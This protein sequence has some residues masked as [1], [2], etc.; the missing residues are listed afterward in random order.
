M[1]FEIG[2]Y[3]LVTDTN[4]SQFAGKIMKIDI[5]GSEIEG[6]RSDRPRKY[7]KYDQLELM[8]CIGYGYINIKI[9]LTDHFKVEVIDEVHYKLLCS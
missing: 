6:W 9:S 4:N 2:Q 1:T 5:A 7:L 8:M 3:V